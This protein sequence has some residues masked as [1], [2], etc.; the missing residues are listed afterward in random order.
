M[1]TEN[2]FL[3]DSCHRHAVEAI[4]E[5]FPQPDIE[6]SFAFVIEAVYAVYRSTFMVASKK[7]EVL[8]VFY[9]VG[10]K[11]THSFKALL[12]TIDIIA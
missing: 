5:Y 1:H 7:E 10:Q 11:K 3:N 2:L 8:R 12:S 9:L 6:S 4:C